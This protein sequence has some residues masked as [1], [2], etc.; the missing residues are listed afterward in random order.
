[1]EPEAGT[2]NILTFADS[3]AT[4]SAKL[5]GAKGLSL[6]L[7]HQK[8][9]PV[10]PGFTITTAI[11]RYFMDHDDQLP[12]EVLEELHRE[13]TQLE[14]LTGY[15]F[16]DARRPLLVSARS[17]AAVSMPGMMDT[18]LN[19]GLTAATYPGIA[20]FG[21]APF[22][23]DCRDRLHA[24]FV[25]I[26]GAA[27]PDDPW[28]QLLVA[29]KSVY[30]SWNNPR[31]R[32]FREW[33]GLDH[34]VGTA[35][36]I[37][38]MVYGNRGIHSGTGVARSCDVNTGD[39]LLC[40][41]YLPNAQGEDV[42]SGT[43]T[44]LQLSALRE[45][46]PVTYGRLEEHVYALE[47]QHG[48]PVE[49]EFT[50]EEGTLYLLQYRK[51]VLSPIAAAVRAVRLV[52]QG[53]I[54]PDQA[55]LRLSQ[56]QTEHLLRAS[57]FDPA[58]LESAKM[59]HLLG[60]GLSASNGVA[61]G[62]VAFTSAV[63]IRMAQEDGT[64]VILV[65]YITDPSDLPGMLA[66][67]GIVTEV[68]GFTSHGAVVANSQ[69]KPAVIGTGALKRPLVEGEWISIDSTATEGFVIAGKLPCTKLTHEN[70]VKRMLEWVRASSRREIVNRSIDPKW[71]ARKIRLNSSFADFYLTWAME[72]EAMGTE[73]EY[74]IGMLRQR[75]H[76]ELASV[77][78]CYLTAAIIREFNDSQSRGAA[79]VCAPEDLAW[80]ESRCNAF[81]G[82]YL[83]PGIVEKISRLEIADQA[84]FFHHAA[85]IFRKGH[86]EIAFCGEP[87]AIIADIV[88]AYLEGVIPDDTT[89]VDQT[90]NLQ[91]HGGRLFD[92]H[93]LVNN[94]F[95][96][97]TVLRGQLNA[98]LNAASI[99]DLFVTVCF[100][101]PCDTGLC[102]TFE[103]SE[104]VM[105]V[106]KRGVQV[107]LWKEKDKTDTAVRV[108][109]AKC[110]K[111]HEPHSCAPVKIGPF[112]VYAAGIHDV[113]AR[114]LDGFRSDSNSVLVLLSDDQIQWH[115]NA[116][117]Y[118]VLAKP[119]VDLN[120]VP[121]DWKE[122]IHKL[123]DLLVSGKRLLI[124]CSKGHGRTG[125]CIASLI[126]FIESSERTP[127]PIAAVRQRHCREAVE[128]RRQAEAVFA[129]RNEPLPTR[130]WPQFPERK[131]KA[132]STSE[133]A[134]TE[135]AP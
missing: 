16:G 106:W 30:R 55:V 129:I 114:D 87:W 33:S 46:L 64:P 54:S 73:L 24:M 94:E 100:P 61:V 95:S 103:A 116:S 105:S 69:R 96:N 40:G 134:E 125:C 115:C 51:A 126:A 90:F 27:P 128:T 48:V 4:D 62:R 81:A 29:I 19:I 8:G 92:K 89:F 68:G 124:A 39:R 74:P 26:V 133:S 35:V 66:A 11:A 83:L 9:M 38:S 101:S 60:S 112:T 42:V 22:A 1:M 53:I 45:T 63:A 135:F 44:P 56:S 47:D 110:E 71:L 79:Y 43:H 58:T 13:M 31:A 72:R 18:I 88:A 20:A 76:A 123:F 120:G 32:D 109:K 23:K 7:M 70:E 17:G 59:N 5:R 28:Q 65:R 119:M 52:D 121:D 37:Q 77:M 97:E 85:A 3:Q 99:E 122:F 84:G 10:P 107:G 57:R 82:T 113:Q 102:F 50:V 118:T 108:C 78:T 14:R 91:H 67:C 127:D 131:N 86:W 6:A 104:D 93:P 98:N 2:S 111:L 117:E 80:I 36:T 21:G 41:E 75:I 25:D 49:I 15:R 34:S 12:S 130:Y 132:V